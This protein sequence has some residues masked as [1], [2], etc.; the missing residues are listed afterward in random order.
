MPSGDL[1]G[2]CKWG[3]L[4]PEWGPLLKGCPPQ[5]VPDT[6]AAPADESHH[7]TRAESQ[8]T[9]QTREPETG[10]LAWR[11]HSLQLPTGDWGS[12]H[13]WP[14]GPRPALA[15]VLERGAWAPHPHPRASFLDR[16]PHRAEAAHCPGGREGAKLPVTGASS[17]PH[18]DPEPPSPV[19]G[20]R[21]PYFPD[22]NSKS[23]RQSDLSHAGSLVE[24]NLHQRQTRVTSGPSSSS[25][26]SPRPHS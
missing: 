4:N 12:L 13:P 8:V 22:S 20:P 15:W 16:K 19:G 26:Q 10:G 25:C 11:G 9:V 24:G 23:S 7:H 21:L 17:S 5:N 14:L 2:R 1:S 3:G 18:P 6:Q